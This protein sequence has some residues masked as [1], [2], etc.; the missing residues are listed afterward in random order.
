MKL[1]ANHEK[2]I[3]ELV[4]VLRPLIEEET[5]WLTPAEV[6]KKF[7]IKQGR[8]KRERL[9]GTLTVVR[10]LKPIKGSQIQDIQYSAKEIESK[11][12]IL[13]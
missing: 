1:T 2:M 9:N 7:K 5:D 4:Q 12:F 13:L 3:K 11:L 10:G 6:E 8:L